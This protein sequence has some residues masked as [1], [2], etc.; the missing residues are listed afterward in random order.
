[1]TTLETGKAPRKRANGGKS[2]DFQ[3]NPGLASLCGIMAVTLSKQGEEL[4][5]CDIQPTSRASSDFDTA[6]EREHDY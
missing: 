2:T 6:H 3:K 5:K 4:G 1:M